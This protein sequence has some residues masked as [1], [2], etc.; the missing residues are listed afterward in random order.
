MGGQCTTYFFK[1]QTIKYSVSTQIATLSSFRTPVW[2][3]SPARVPF[4]NIRSASRG[5]SAPC[6]YLLGS[7]GQ[8]ATGVSSRLECVCGGRLTQLAQRGSC[9]LPLCA[10]LI[11]YIVVCL[12]YT[13]EA[14][15]AVSSVSPTS[16][17]CQIIAEKR[18]AQCPP[19]DS[20]RPRPLMISICGFNWLACSQILP[21]FWK[22]SRDIKPQICRY[23]H[24][25][26]NFSKN[27]I[28]VSLSLVGTAKFVFKTLLP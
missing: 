2:R 1:C 8:E 4:R 17:S 16:L 13:H 27:Y 26:V 22:F 11:T 19:T 25:L 18:T 7:R 15:R 12:S 14:N 28:S 3:A 6:T 24:F 20:R 23:L 9:P 10:S 5:R 21:L